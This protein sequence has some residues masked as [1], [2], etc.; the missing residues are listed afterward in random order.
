MVAVKVQCAFDVLGFLQVSD[1]SYISIGLPARIQFNMLSRS[2]A[3]YS[4]VR[5]GTGITETMSNAGKAM[6]H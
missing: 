4:G 5:H 3:L 6:V 2:L 1:F